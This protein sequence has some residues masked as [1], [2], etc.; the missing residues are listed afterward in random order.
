VDRVTAD[1]VV[2]PVAISIVVDP[3]EFYTGILIRGGVLLERFCP[4]FLPLRFS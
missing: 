4:I 2:G 3:A 1:R